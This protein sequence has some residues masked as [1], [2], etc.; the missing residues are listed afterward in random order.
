MLRP[1]GVERRALHVAV[2]R[3][4]DH[5][6]PGLDQA[7]VVEVGDALHDLGQPRRGDLRADGAELLRH[8]LQAAGAA[9]EDLQQLADAAGDLL[10]LRRDLVALQAG[11]ALQGQRQ[12]AAG[13]RVR[14][15]HRA[16]GGHDVAGVLHQ[17]E[18]GVDIAG[19]PGARHQ[20][21][22]GLRRVAARA[23]QADHLVDVGDRDGEADQQVPA[24]PRLGQAVAAAAEDHL[25]AEADKGLQRVAQAHLPRPAVVQRQEV[26]REGGLELRHAVELVQHHL[27]RR[28]ALQLD[29][30]AQPVAVALVAEVGDA[31]HLLG[32]H[33]LGDAL[34][35]RRLVDLVGHLADGDALP[36]AAHLL[37]LAAG[38][39]R[40]G[41]AA[42]LEGGADA[43]APED[44]P[45]GREVRAGHDPHQRVERR[46][47]V[48]DQRQRRVDD[49]ARVVRRDVGGHADGDAVGAVDEQVRE[50]GG[51]HP[52]LAVA[53]VVVG[54]EV[55][56]VLVDA[57]QQ[58]RGRLG[59]PQLGVAHGRRR[60]AVHGAEIALAVDQ[61]HA[62]GEGLRHPHHGVVDGGVAVR[63]VLAHHLADDARRLAVRLV[64]GEAALLHGVEDAAM[65]GLEAVAR[66]RQGAGD[67]DAH[68][69]VEVGAPHLLL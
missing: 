13:L 2:A 51:Q 66:V 30:D 48:G 36:A 5:H 45:A 53:V 4:G 11:E 9:A 15:P 33:Q 39:E 18:Q 41:A 26:H 54:L 59:Q 61:R 67:D 25:L 22:A 1:E 38:A 7:L 32:A 37:D 40:D 65:D 27:R 43:R 42:G 19:R 24:L 56:G 23:D 17:G 10:Q 47:R 55:D 20:R 12:D 21:G 44:Q 63:V 64:G 57:L 8:H 58:R 6:Q 49:L 52:R 68:G 35:Q 31:L 50:G 60:I 29:D 62:Q 14:Q 34:E 28:V 46:V 16:V 69:V 3:Q